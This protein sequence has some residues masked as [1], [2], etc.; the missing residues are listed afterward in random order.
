MKKILILGASS[1]IGTELIKLL[2]SN[3]SLIPILHYNENIKFYK[4]YFKKFQLIKSNFKSDSFDSIDKTFSNDY[5]IIV[6]LIGYIDNVS[7]KNFNLDNI[8]ETL[9]INSIIPMMIIRKSLQHMIKKQYGNIINTSSI[10][11]KFGG[12]K[13]TFNYSISKY[14]NEFIPSEIRNLYKKNIYYNILKIGFT[15]TKMHQLINS[16]NISKR[17]SHVPMRKAAKPIEIAKTIN[18]LISEDSSYV[19]GQIISI[20][21]GE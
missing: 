17:L 20:S 16:K 7:F 4:K 15:D 6:N 2:Q 13:N 8:F 9:K 12:G 1:D 10:G 19:N 3:K 21:G 5:D 14:L 18:F 11:V